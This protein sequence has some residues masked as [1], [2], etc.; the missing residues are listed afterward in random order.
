M[1]VERVRVAALVGV[2][3][4]YLALAAIE[5]RR[6][7]AG[8]LRGRLIDMQ[9]EDLLPAQAADLREVTFDQQQLAAVGQLLV[10]DLGPVPLHALELVV[11]GNAQVQEPVVLAGD[12]VQ[13]GVV[14]IRG[15][16]VDRGEGPA[17]KQVPIHHQQGVHLLRGVGGE[18]RHERPGRGVD[19]GDI[20]GMHA[21][22]R[23]ELPADVG[24][25]AVAAVEGDRV[26]LA[27]D[28]GSPGR[29]LEPR[30]RAEAEDVVPGIGGGE[31]LDLGEAAHRVH[32]AAAL[33]ELADGF[34]GAGRRQL[35]RP[36]GRGGRHRP[37]LRRLLGGGAGDRGAGH[38]G[39]LKGAASGRG[40]AREHRISQAVRFTQQ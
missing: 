11:A 32:G 19:L 5:L 12:R 15:A 2:A 21:V 30:G 7:P 25:V 22:D 14:R 10:V 1:D 26:D 8:D 36:G 6:A 16:A 40:N 37:C 3:A 39:E 34:R 4:R 13:A 29:D 27:I 24:V 31:P 35:R 38:R 23:G 18:S 9:H 17:G 28:V 20:A 33:H